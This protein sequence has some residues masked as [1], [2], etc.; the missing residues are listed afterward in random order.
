MFKIA[1]IINSTIRKKEKLISEIKTHFNDKNFDFNIFYS[2]K[3]RHIENLVTESLLQQFKI[4]VL[5]GGDGTLN[6]G[7]NGALHFAQIEHKLQL[8]DFDLKKLASIKFALIPHG[9]GNDFAKTIGLSKNVLRLKQLILEEKTK[10][11]DIGYTQF[12]DENKNATQR[13]YINICDV[14]M[15]GIIAKK[16]IDKNNSFHPDWIYIKAIFTTLLRYKNTKMLFEN[17][18]KKSSFQ[19]MSLIFANGKFFGSGLGISP[20][21]SITDGIIQV[22]KI[23]DISVWDYIKQLGNLKKSRFIKH[24]E[25][26]Y[27][28]SKKLKVSPADEQD[29]LIDMDGEFVGYAPLQIECVPQAINFI[30]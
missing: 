28:Q 14:G 5:V 22:I 25:V 7:I 12:Y 18:D 10:A 3:S 15:G 19:A 24:N 23:G 17:E 6:E 29:L 2:E 20:D 26:N 13:F 4:I 30:Y 1:F 27:S 8:N 9:S 21:A 16:I 11:I